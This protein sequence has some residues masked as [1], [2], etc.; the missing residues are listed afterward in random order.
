M[1]I[2]NRLLDLRPVIQS[3]GRELGATV[4]FREVAE[5]DAAHLAASVWAAVSVDSGAVAR[6][7][8]DLGWTAADPRVPLPAAWTD[9]Y[10]NL[11][12]ALF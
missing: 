2:S 10:S 7:V 12:A 1:H 4:A 3:I 6:L 8:Q 11:L 9:R 5:D